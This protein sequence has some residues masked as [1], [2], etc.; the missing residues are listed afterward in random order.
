MVEVT[1]VGVVSIAVMTVAAETEVGS[2][3]LMT[4]MTVDPDSDPVG[5]AVAVL[6][7]VTAVTA[8]TGVTATIG[9]TAAIEAIVVTEVTG[10][11]ENEVA[12]VKE[13]PELLNENAVAGGVV[14][15]TVMNLPVIPMRFKP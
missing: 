15:L 6:V 2:V 4:E 3:V 5:S 14:R 10:T 9:L 13:I 12:N 7:I 1:A 11:K 8:A